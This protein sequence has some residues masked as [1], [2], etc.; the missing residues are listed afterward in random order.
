MN[1]E[2]IKMADMYAQGNLV[3]NIEPTFDYGRPRG[4]ILTEPQYTC[5]QIHI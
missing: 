4:F 1:Y 3:K 2:K 5:F